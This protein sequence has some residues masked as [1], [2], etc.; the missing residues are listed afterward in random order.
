[1]IFRVATTLA[2]FGL[3]MAPVAAHADQDQG[4]YQ[5]AAPEDVSYEDAMGCSSL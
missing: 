4:A 3:A 5:P 1:M 2:L